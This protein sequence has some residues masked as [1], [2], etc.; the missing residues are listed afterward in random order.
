MEF[1]FSIEYRKGQDNVVVD[2]LSRLDN[3]ECKSLITLQLESHLLTRIKQSWTADSN[4]QKLITKVQKNVPAH[5]HYSWQHDELRRKGR[6]VVGNDSLLRKEILQWLH[7][8]ASGGHSGVNATIK[9][10]KAVVYW[11][12]FYTTLTTCQ[13]NKSDSA[14]S[15]GLL[16]PL[17][18]PE[19]IWQHITMDFIEG[20]LSS[21]GKQVIFVVVDRLSKAAHFMTLFHPYSAKEV[22]QSFL[23]NVFKLHGF[24]HT[25]TSDRDYVFVSQFWQELMAVQGVKIQLS[26]NYHPQTDGQTKVVNRFLGTYSRCMCAESPQNWV[27]WLSLAEWWY[28]TTYHTATKATPYEIMYGQLPPIHLPY[29]LGESNI[30]LVDRSLAKKGGNAKSNQIPFEK[31]ARKN[32]AS[33]LIGTDLIGNMRLVIEFV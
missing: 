23:D 22:A 11:K 14:A 21:Y 2:A 29:L 20:L 10:V 32:E 28:N 3:V 27:K 5:K 24:P 17:P 13:Q 6:L 33:G 16:Q 18:I 19:N 4:L 8:S 7:A 15:P 25:I 31:G 12:T 26:T 9:R 1:D 30:E